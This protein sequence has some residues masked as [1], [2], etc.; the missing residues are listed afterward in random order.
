MLKLEKE[1]LLLLEQYPD[2]IQQAALEYNPS[3]IA[4]YIFS[5]AQTYNSFYAEH[6]VLKAE[7]EEKK[8]LRLRICQLTANVIKHAM[9]LL[10]IKVPERM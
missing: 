6:S 1:L 5:V 3:S 9:N 8:Q 10:G 2:I 7:S 4:N